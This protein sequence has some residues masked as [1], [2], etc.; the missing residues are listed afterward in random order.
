MFALLLLCLV[1]G[2]L[3]GEPDQ[4]TMLMA[5]TF[6]VVFFTAEKAV[7]VGRLCEPTSEIDSS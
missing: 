7:E 4:P 1:S 6:G 2:R 5:F 3:Q